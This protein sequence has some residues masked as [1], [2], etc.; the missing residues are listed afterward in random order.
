MAGC[1]T[2][3]VAFSN[4]GSG[5]VIIKS[6]NPPPACSLPQPVGKMSVTV[7]KAP[8]CVN[9]AASSRIEHVFITLQSIRLRP[10]SPIRTDS[11][12]LVELAPALEKDPHQVD[13][14]GDS[15]SDALLKGAIVPAGTYQELQM[16]LLSGHQDD[17][18]QLATENACGDGQWN[19]IITGDGRIQPLYGPGPSPEVV[20]PFKVTDGT[21]LVVL[22]NSVIDLEVQW[23]RQTILASGA[24]GFRMLNILVG[25]VEIR[26]QSPADAES[27]ASN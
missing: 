14:A 10:S 6:G 11:V 15:S 25:T 23:A 20:V 21:P 1:N 22:P 27:S 8:E 5:G 13:L 2:C 24:G 9:C 3:F 26:K 19:C 17:T 12:E 18:L 16:R 7:R 4:N